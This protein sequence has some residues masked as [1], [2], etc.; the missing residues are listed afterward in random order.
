MLLRGYL[1]N[2][3]HISHT[4]KN[5]TN[6]I[7]EN[8]MP[9]LVNVMFFEMPNEILCFV[10]VP[11]NTIRKSQVTS[12]SRQANT[13]GEGSSSLLPLSLIGMLQVIG[14]GFGI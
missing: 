1:V 5:L 10:N 9:M 4:Q 3:H 13:V 8:G 11:P 12:I 6:G 14:E 7:L 2:I